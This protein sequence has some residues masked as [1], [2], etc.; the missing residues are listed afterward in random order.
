MDVN[1]GTSFEELFERNLE[2]LE[3]EE[4][5]DHKSFDRKIDILEN[6]EYLGKGDGQENV[7]VKI[8]FEEDSK[9]K[10]DASSSGSGN[11]NNNNQNWSLQNAKHNRSETELDVI[12]N[13]KE[14]KYDFQNGEPRSHA[15]RWICCPCCRKRAVV[16]TCEIERDKAIANNKKALRTIK[17]D[18]RKQ[19]CLKCCKKFTAFLFSH[20]GLCSLVVA[21]TIM[22]G[23]VF[24]ALE[25]PAEI[26]E[27]YQVEIKRK[28]QVEKLWN[29]TLFHNIFSEVNW[30]READNV[31]RAFQ[32]DIYKATKESGWDG[33][34][35][36][37][38]VQWSFAGSLLYSITVI[39]TI[40]K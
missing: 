15:R 2:T 10:D 40:G 22:G 27:R 3:I 18:K 1:N 34:D 21:Y 12:D 38:D 33:K 6:D 31:L 14:V 24:R 25:A 19:Q 35:G 4:D 29:I 36:E 8:D 16:S 7:V 32:A 23:F 28:V 5:E 30:S 39:T 13:M 26:H 20:I 37:E 11:K 17:L 9:T